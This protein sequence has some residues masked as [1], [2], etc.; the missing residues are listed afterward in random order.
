MRLSKEKK[1]P[2]DP[3][4]KCTFCKKKRMQKQY[5]TEQQLDE[6]A[7]N[8]DNIVQRYVETPARE[9]APL[10][11]ILKNVQDLWREWRAANPKN[12]A[13]SDRLREMFLKQERWKD[14]AYRDQI[15]FNKMTRHTTTEKEIEAIVAL[16]RLKER[17]QRGEMTADEGKE[18]WANYLLTHFG[19]PEDEYRRRHPQEKVYRHSV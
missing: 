7:K 3:K 19:V 8:P 14:F 12:E 6:L 1:I 15:M 4:K 11:V 13:D 18:Q 16:I 9:Q 5:F 17:Q 10:P 2:E